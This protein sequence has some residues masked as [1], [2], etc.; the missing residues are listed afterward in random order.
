M[1]FRLTSFAQEADHEFI[2]VDTIQ[3]QYLNENKLIHIYLPPDYYNS[4]DSYPLQVVLGGL[5]RTRLYYTTNEYLSRTYQILDLNH[6]HT[7]PE[8]I[9]V[10][11]S[12]APP[13]NFDGFNKFI[14]NEVIPLVESKYRKTNYKSLIGHSSDGEFVLH[15]LFSKESPFMGYFCTAP[16]H[17]DFFIDK[18][19]NPETIATLNKSKKSLYLGVSRQ[20]YFYSEN[21]KLIDAFNSNATGTFNFHPSIKTSDTHH[22]IF[23]NLITDALIFIYQKWHFSIPLSHPERTTEQFIA[24]YNNLSQQTGIEIT[25]PEFDFYLLA[26]ILDSRKL[27]DEKIELLKK[28]KAY[29]PKADNAD[30]YLART[31]YS[32]GD[33][34]KALKH[35]NYALTLNPDNIFAKQ[36]KSLIN[37]MHPKP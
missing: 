21:I 19:N 33:F 35:N 6:L 8:S 16:T 2:F 28:C 12:T 17:S 13:D 9:I 24:H 10:G 27:I 23:P 25:P 29:Y 18:L 30:A 11:L 36:T 1:A 31:Y 22:T 3:S 32:L 26:Y 14:V 5:S 34:Q 4:K 37:K 20:D 7:I 15:D